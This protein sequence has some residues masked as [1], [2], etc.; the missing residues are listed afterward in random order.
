MLP[1]LAHQTRSPEE[2]HLIKE[3]ARKITSPRESSQNDIVSVS[4][5][6]GFEEIGSR[7]RTGRTDLM[8][9]RVCKIAYDFASVIQTALSNTK[10]LRL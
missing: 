6:R 10:G 5:E 8:D 4:A 7:S 1:I 2:L 9:L 3:V